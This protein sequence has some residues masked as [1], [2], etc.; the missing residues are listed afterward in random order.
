MGN[1]WNRT[2]GGI[3]GENGDGP[4]IKRREGLGFHWK[5][6]SLGK[7]SKRGVQKSM[8]GREE[9]TNKGSF[10]AGG[11]PG[12]SRPK[13]RREEKRKLGGNPSQV[14]LRTIVKRPKRGEKQKEG[15]KR[16]GEE[17]LNKNGGDECRLGTSWSI[18]GRKKSSGNLKALT[19]DRG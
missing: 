14:N 5:L 7:T 10:S 19:W 4:G 12:E 11:D 3:E 9:D 13:K 18:R 1:T 6:N 15:R 2:L 16:V 17:L 8:T